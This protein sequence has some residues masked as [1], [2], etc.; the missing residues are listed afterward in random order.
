MSTE[1]YRLPG[2][3]ILTLIGSDARPLLQR[4]ITADVEHLEPGQCRPGALLTPQGKIISDFMLFP[5]EDGLVIDIAEQAAQALKKRLTMYK[6]KADV[7]I[8]IDD[9]LAS[10]WAETAFDGAAKDPR[11]DHVF[12]SIGAPGDTSERAL[13][14]IEIAAGVPSFS[15]DYGEAEVFP[16]DVNLDVYGGIGWTKGC[17]IGQEVVSRMKRRGTIRKRSLAVSFE[18]SAPATGSDLKAGE[19]TIGEISST[20][21]RHAVSRVRLDRLEKSDSPVMADGRVAHI[22]LPEALKPETP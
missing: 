11:L 17:F 9:S 21:G 2:R 22:E 5:R 19:S 13:D 15:R 7:E 12:R 4:V 10:L 20:S 16:T 1:L 6:L 18:N 3:S 14:A 8:A